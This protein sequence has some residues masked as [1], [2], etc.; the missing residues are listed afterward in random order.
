MNGLVL[1]LAPSAYVSRLTGGASR[2]K[3]GAAKGIR[4]PRERIPLPSEVSCQR[5]AN[6]YPLIYSWEQCP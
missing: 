5:S 3:N 4:Q 6:S 1:A 2:H